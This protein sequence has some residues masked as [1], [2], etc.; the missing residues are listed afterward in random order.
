[1]R[2]C[3]ALLVG[4]CHCIIGSIGMPPDRLRVESTDGSHRFELVPGGV[5]SVRECQG[6][7]THNGKVVWKGALI[8]NVAPARAFVASRR[9]WVVTQ[10]EWMDPD[11]FALVI[12]DGRGHVRMSYDLASLGIQRRSHWLGNSLSFFDDEC[13]HF[14]IRSNTGAIIVIDLL[15]NRIV[16]ERTM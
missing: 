15:G 5:G 7:L 8:N 16:P 1:M 6:K 11:L 3:L 10:G 4:L 13:R 9:G 14:V 12:Y 2:L